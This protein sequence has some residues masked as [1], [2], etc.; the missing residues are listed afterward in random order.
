MLSLSA[1]TPRV[2]GHPVRDLP[3]P[4]TV[5][6]SCPTRRFS[7]QTMRAD[8]RVGHGRRA[9]GCP[10]GL[11]RRLGRAK[12][13]TPRNAECVSADLRGGAGASEASVGPWPG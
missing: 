10:V 11:A 9:G 2:A 7:A 5:A 3:R 6:D 13:P 12:S 1:S 8:I 4:A